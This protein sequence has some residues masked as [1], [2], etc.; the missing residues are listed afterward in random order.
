M[1]QVHFAEFELEWHGLET[2]PSYQHCAPSSQHSYWNCPWWG[3]FEWKVEVLWLLVEGQRKM[4]VDFIMVIGVASV[5]G[6]WQNKYLPNVLL[7]HNNH[8]RDPWNECYTH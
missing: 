7:S 2:P 6:T 1:I 3:K 4:L 5:L 8:K